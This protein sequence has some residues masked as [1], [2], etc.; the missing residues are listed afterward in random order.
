M[1][2]FVGLKAKIYGYLIDQGIE[3]KKAKDKKSVTLKEHLNLKI[4]KTV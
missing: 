1:T 2:K 3:G 4:I